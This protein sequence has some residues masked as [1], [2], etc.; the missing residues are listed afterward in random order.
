MT[1][2]NP[3]PYRSKAHIPPQTI[4]VY[5]NKFQ[6]IYGVIL[7]DDEIGEFNQRLKK[8]IAPGIP[9]IAIAGAFFVLGLLSII[10]ETF[11]LGDASIA[12]FVV[13]LILFCAGAAGMTSAQK[14]LEMNF[15]EEVKRA[16]PASQVPATGTFVGTSAPYGQQ[17]SMPYG[18]QAGPIYGQQPP[19]SNQVIVK[20]TVIVKIRCQY[21]GKLVD[22]GLA[23][24]PNC[25]G[26]M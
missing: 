12:M 9:C 2:A 25:L 3:A 21:C 1:M 10:T 19:S 18:Q 14:R 4:Q 17:P 11:F 6:T 23:E 13:G 5:R 24:C 15:A 8:T 16:R 7:T 22:Q 26:K 20:E